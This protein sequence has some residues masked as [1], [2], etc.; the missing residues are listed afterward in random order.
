MGLCG[1]GGGRFWRP[2]RAIAIVYVVECNRNTYRERHEIGAVSGR[3]LNPTRTL[4]SI[5]HGEGN[6]KR[7]W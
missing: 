2:K 3:P 5:S 7:S 6:V 1:I 4:T